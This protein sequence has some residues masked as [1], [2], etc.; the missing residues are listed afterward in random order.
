[1]ARPKLAEGD[2]VPV[3]TRIPEKLDEAVRA[4]QAET[5]LGRS[6][7]VRELLERG[8]AAG[9][10]LTGHTRAKARKSATRASVPSGPCVHP[11]ARRIG[12][13]CGQCGDPKAHTKGTKK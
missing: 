3:S 13:G 12:D 5:G 2:S 6:E 4:F 9:Q 1:M 10:A 7:A 8:L 11:V